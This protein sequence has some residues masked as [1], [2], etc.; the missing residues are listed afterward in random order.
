M[1]ASF[2]ALVSPLTD[3]AS[4]KRQLHNDWIL[5]RKPPTP[6]VQPPNLADCKP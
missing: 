6:P 1:A 2:A 5:P 4:V 3:L